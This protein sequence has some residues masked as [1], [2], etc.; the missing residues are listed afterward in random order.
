[1]S[2]SWHSGASNTNKK[3]LTNL[4]S[5][6]QSTVKPNT[7]PQRQDT[8]ISTNL[9]YLHQIIDPHLLAQI[10]AAEIHHQN[11]EESMISSITDE[12]KQRMST[13]TYSME[14]VKKISLV[15]TFNK[16]DSCVL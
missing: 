3:D 14:E 13:S 6:P 9:N 10:H 12:Q 16:F 5:N 7:A 4:R 15:S 11:I 1:M 8:Y 2:A